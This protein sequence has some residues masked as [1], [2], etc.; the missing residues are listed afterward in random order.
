MRKIGTVTQTCEKCHGLGAVK[1]ANQVVTVEL[2]NHMELR[3]EFMETCPEC[4]GSGYVIVDI[5]GEDGG[6]VNDD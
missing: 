3:V 2:A 5:M 1:L 4:E 6:E